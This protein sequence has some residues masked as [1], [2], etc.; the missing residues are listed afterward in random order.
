[1]VV[2]RKLALIARRTQT[3]KS[4]FQFLLRVLYRLEVRGQVP[5]LRR[6]LVVANHQSFLD[7]L[8]LSTFLPENT[9]WVVH[10]QIARQAFFRTLLRGVDYIVVD[11]ARPMALKATIA[12]LEA[13][14]TV[15]VFPEGRVTVS[16]APLMKIYDGPAFIAAR[17]GAQVVP[18]ILDGAVRARGFSRMKGDFELAWFPKITATILP[19]ST[20]P[21]PV[22]PSGKLRRRKASEAMGRLLRRALAASYR[23]RSVHQAM[24][25]AIERHGRGR[26]M[27]ED[28][29]GTELTYGSLLK[30]AL[31]LGRLASKITAEGENVGV[32]L[33]NAAPTLALVF[34]L[35]S[36]RRVAAILNFTSGA[37][38]VQSALRAACV[39]TVLSSRTFIERAK[40]GPLVER[41]EG[42]NIVYLEDLRKRLTLG[43]KLWLI[44]WALPFPRH[45]V[46]G[47]AP[48]DPA[49]I[50]FTSGSEG[51]P[52][53]VLLSHWNL[54]C[55]V[56]QSLL[57]EDL[58]RAD[59]LFA[60]LPVFHSFGLLAGFIL[61]VISGIRVFLYPSPLHYSMVPEM[62]YDR[63]AT[64]LFATPT[65]LGH[66]A[67]RAHPYD[68]RRVRLLVAGGEKLPED[69]RQLYLEKFGLRVV[70]GYGATECSPV[71][72]IAGHLHYKPGTVGEPLPLLE[73]RLEPVEGIEHGGTLHVRG[74]N[75]MLGYLRES[76]PGVVE[77]PSSCFG[78]GWYNTGDL[79]VVDEDN[80]LHVLGRLKRFAKVAGEMIALETV[81]QLAEAASPGAQHGAVT[82]PEAGR[83]EMIVLVTTDGTLRREALL[84]VAR[85]HGTA[86]LAIPRRIIVIEK[87][88]LLGNGKRDYP[89]LARLVE[90]RLESQ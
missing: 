43:D 52:K 53:G 33:P 34:G 23:P 49:V 42:V 37:R 78:P 12:A 73:W 5:D 21:M 76:A 74:P 26:D 2:R 56:R 83:G 60:A 7:A 35:F 4:F 75:V 36:A 59:K 85:E 70:E 32:L 20:I 81:E 11:A 57:A 39:K 14:R 17:S 47:P 9:L 58:S 54:L 6:T 69:V 1:V 50:L 13:G 3:L 24:L 64:I 71:I 79:A 38:G 22:A 87:L 29:S 89:A 27:V 72:A 68:L 55:C 88:P 15:M 84:R 41:L 31:A 77:P 82:R 19:G 61:P 48:D 40:L 90:E 65:F 80:L 30:G 51:S 25:D 10:S 44:L 18:V 28:F 16:G 86:E 66:Y 8:I 46:K 63:D 45:A 67:R 62:V